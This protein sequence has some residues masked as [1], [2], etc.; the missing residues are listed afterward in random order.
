[1]LSR[2]FP[3]TFDNRYRG[4]PAAIWLLVPITILRLIMGVNSIWHPLYVAT[5]ADGIPL[6][7][8]AGGGA[9]A[10]ISIYASLGLYLLL[11][12]LLNVLVLIRYRAMI[13][14]MYVLLLV[15]QLAGIALNHIYPIAK[16]GGSSPAA[17]LAVVFAILALT[18]TG[19]VL[20]L[21]TRRERMKP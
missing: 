3:E 9:E 18:L 16:A 10:V 7:R 1:M 4:N 14:L 11:L 2:I 19:L 15:E 6:D 17:G 12:A 5:S 13:P 8:Y 21:I 20:S